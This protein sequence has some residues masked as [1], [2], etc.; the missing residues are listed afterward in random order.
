MTNSANPVTT[1]ITVTG[2][3]LETVQQFKYFGAIINEQGS[4]A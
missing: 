3:E 2:K 1:R 4:K